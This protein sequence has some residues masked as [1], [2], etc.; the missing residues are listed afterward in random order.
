MSCFFSED[1]D[2]HDDDDLECLVDY[3]CEWDEYCYRGDCVGYDT[4]IH[5]KYEKLKVFAVMINLYNYLRISMIMRWPPVG[6][7]YITLD[8][9]QNFQGCLTLSYE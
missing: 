7:T 1:G 5:Q 4:W 6:R 9:F 8:C 3:H 2:D